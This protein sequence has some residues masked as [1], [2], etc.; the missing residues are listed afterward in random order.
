M[1]KQKKLLVVGLIFLLVI[2]IGTLTAFAFQSGNE[3]RPNNFCFRMKKS[4]R[5]FLGFS[6]I[7][8][9]LVIGFFQFYRFKNNRRLLKNCG[10]REQLPIAIA[11]FELVGLLIIFRAV[12]SLK[13]TD[14]EVNEFC[15]TLTS[16]QR[17]LM[18]TGVLFL[19]IGLF[20]KISLVI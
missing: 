7:F 10:I 13:Q 11:V 1:E 6:S 20:E 15:T 8:V 19:W 3:T 16:D 9:A 17:L 5:N 12:F 4:R 2:S 18:R 14:D